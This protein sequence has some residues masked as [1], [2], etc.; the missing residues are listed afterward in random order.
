MASTGRSVR[1][2]RV[3]SLVVLGSAAPVLGAGFSI[4]EQGTKAMGMAGAFTAQADDPSAMFHNVGGLA[5]F[6]EQ[7][8]SLGFT[9]ITQSEADFEGTTPFPGPEAR[10]EME[11]LS[12]APPHF[13]WVKPINRRWNFGLG[14]NAPFG[15]GN[16]WSDQDN[17]AGRFISTKATLT[18][19]DIN[20]NLGLRLS[21]RF[22]IGFGVIVRVSE[23]ELNRRAPA[24]DPFQRAAGRRRPGGAGERLRHRLR[25]A[26]GLP[27]QT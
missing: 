22:G 4:F 8:F 23:I 2:L 9:Y 6:D 26:G 25:L 15:L 18:E 12:E 21:D 17:F 13:Y 14:V 20:P 5:F 27:A 10:A 3:L 16:E 24:I 11:T 19:L 1:A 7:K